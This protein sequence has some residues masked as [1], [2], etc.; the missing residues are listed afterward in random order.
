[1]GQKLI[2]HNWKVSL[3]NDAVLMDTGEEEEDEVKSGAGVGEA[4]SFN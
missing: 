3:S 1:M 4:T 2:W